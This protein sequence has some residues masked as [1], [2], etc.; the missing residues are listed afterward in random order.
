MPI[1]I[2]LIGWAF[3]VGIGVIIALNFE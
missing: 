2:D 3:I 1:W